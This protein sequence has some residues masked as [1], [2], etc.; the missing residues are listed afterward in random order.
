MSVRLII[1]ND[2]Q[3]NHLSLH[4]TDNGAQL[5]QQVQTGAGLI[6]MRERAEELGG[7]CVIKGTGTGCN[8]DGYQYARGQRH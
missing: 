3:S 1:E 2:A 7:T 8:L 4:I 6:S 5:P